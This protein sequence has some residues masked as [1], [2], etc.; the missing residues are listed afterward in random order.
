M[1]Q[2]YNPIEIDRQQT[3]ILNGLTT[4]FSSPTLKESRLLV[5]E[6]AADLE[7]YEKKFYQVKQPT[8][9]SVVQEL[10]ELSVAQF[11]DD[12]DRDSMQDL[13]FSQVDLLA[14]LLGIELN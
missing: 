12:L 6:A 3:R 5:A 8:V 13:F 11:D 4:A 2:E 1:N 10:Y 7:D 9:K 14:E